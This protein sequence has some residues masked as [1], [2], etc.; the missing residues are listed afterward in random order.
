MPKGKR[1]ED[2][3]LISPALAAAVRVTAALRDVGQFVIGREAGFTTKAVFGEVMRRRRVVAIDDRRIHRLALIADYAGPLFD[4]G[5]IRVEGA[6]V[7]HG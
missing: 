3:A 4:A 5:S 7:S 1:L 2:I 6:T